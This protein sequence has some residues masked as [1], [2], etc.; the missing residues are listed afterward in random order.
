MYIIVGLGNIG[1]KYQGTRHNIG[2]DTVEYLA[3]KHDIKINK[4][5]HKAMLGEG[6]I[7]GEKVILAQPQTFMNLSGEAVLALVNYYDLPLENLIVIYDDIDIELG[8]LRIRKKGSAGTHNG[9][10]N[11]I[12][13]LNDDKFPRIRIGVGRD[14]RMDLKDFVLSRYHKDEVKPMETAVKRC[15][16][17]IECLISDGVDMAMNKYNVKA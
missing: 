3:S 5:K 1:R 11:I 16:E 2:F 13:L 4:L 10:K 12:M 6:I 8:A 17:A 14:E 7:A 9:M 15:C